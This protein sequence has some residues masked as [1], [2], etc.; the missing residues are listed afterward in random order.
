[1]DLAWEDFKTYLSNKP[2]SHKHYVELSD[3]YIVEALNGSFRINCVIEKGSADETDFNANYK[4]SYDKDLSLKLDSDNA[5]VVNP[6]LATAGRTYQSMFANFTTGKFNALTCVDQNNQPDGQ[7]IH[8]LYDSN[9]DEITSSANEANA[10]L[11]TIEW[12][13]AI[14]YDI[15]GFCL[16]QK[17]QPTSDVIL[18]AI[19]AHHI[20]PQYGGSI[21]AI[22]GCNLRFAPF[23]ARES[24]WVGDSTSAVALDPV[25]G[26]HHQI[27]KLYHPAGFQHECMVE[28]IWYV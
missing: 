11:T 1:M 16:Y 7:F 12:E 27:L 22:R 19:A 23:G 13:P 17:T 4:T 6:K 10:V 24:D 5:Q 2:N 9:G 25:Y 3:K 20:P 14:A 28:V 26:S 21:V 18:S 15:Q 8:V